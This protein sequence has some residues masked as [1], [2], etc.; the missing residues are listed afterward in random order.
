MAYKYAHV[1]PLPVKD[2]PLNG[3]SSTSSVAAQCANSVIKL[4]P[5]SRFHI[6]MEHKSFQML[7]RSLRIS[8]KVVIYYSPNR[9]IPKHL[10]TQKYPKRVPKYYK[11]ESMI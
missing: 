6:C 1:A 2:R 5:K 11:R 10:I 7:L 3:G 9:K 4:T 8:D